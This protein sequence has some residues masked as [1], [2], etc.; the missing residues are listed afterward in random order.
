MLKVY[1]TTWCPDC[2]RAKR[3]LNDRHIAFEEIN[4]ETMPGADQLVRTHNQGKA[5]VPTFDLDGRYFA[6]SPFTP[7]QFAR[8]L[9]LN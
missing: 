7:T 6:A 9:G 2:V 3:F 4:I 8:D 1:T 5:R